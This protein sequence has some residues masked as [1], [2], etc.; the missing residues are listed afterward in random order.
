MKLMVEYIEWGDQAS[1]RFTA[2]NVKMETTKL[3]I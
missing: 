2:E 1:L 3:V